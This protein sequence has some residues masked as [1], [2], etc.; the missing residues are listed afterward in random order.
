MLAYVLRGIIF[1]FA[2]VSL[3]AVSAKEENLTPEEE[4]D[5]MENGETVNEDENPSLDNA[6]DLQE[7]Q[8]FWFF[9]E[10]MKDVHNLT[11]NQNEEKHK[12]IKIGVLR[13]TITT[14][15]LSA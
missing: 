3:A 5:L 8:I 11:S 2:V 12:E 1:F 4:L 10:T 14:T 6:V 9:P 15:T 13:D 7:G